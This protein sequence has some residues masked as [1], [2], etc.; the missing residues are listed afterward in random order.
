MH[1]V[2]EKLKVQTALEG[3]VQKSGSSLRITAQLS[4][5]ADGYNLWS[6]KYDRELKDVF[7]IQDEI[8]SAIVDTL[9][10]KLTT[11]ERKRIVEHPIDNIAAYEWYLRARPEI[12]RFTKESVDLALQYLQ[13]GLNLIGENAALYAGLAA[14]YWQYFNI[15]VMQE[16]GVAKA[17]EYAQKALALD[18]NLALAHFII[19]ELSGYK[20]YPENWHEMIHHCKLALA[21]NPYSP[22]ALDRLSY[23]YCVAGKFSMALPLIEKFMKVD[24]LNPRTFFCLGSYYLFGGK[25]GLAAEQFQKQC[26]A[27]P[28][29]PAAQICYALTLSY[30]KEIDKALDIIDQCAK[31][32]PDNVLTK[33]GLLLKFGLLKDKEKALKIL[34]PDF[35]QTCK[36]DFVWSYN[37]A[38]G[39]SLADAKKEALDWLEH[40]INRGFINYPLLAEKDLFLANIRGEPRFKKLME[41][42]KYEWEH[43]EE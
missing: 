35:Q 37:V 11:Q 28:Q 12:F 39:L 15:G 27:D 41:R 38:I 20:N 13:N 14:V 6:A 40:A 1:E 36:R 23:D 24:P 8:S 18:P 43:F 31:I 32:N 9:R 2:G 10:L 33:F 42:V 19:G 5:I 21:A 25:Y 17:N 7:A 26:Q 29:D 22:E 34:T 16:D 3:T 4:N 30:N